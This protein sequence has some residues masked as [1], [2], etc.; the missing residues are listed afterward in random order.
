MLEKEIEAKFRNEIHDLGGMALKFI[1]PSLVGVP[2]RLVLMP[3]GKALFVEFKAPN[4]KMRPLQQMRKNQLTKLG[5]KVYYIDN[6]EKIR[7]VIYEIST[8]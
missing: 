3:N 2:D 5:F 4:K 1:S 6:I 8:T 7:E